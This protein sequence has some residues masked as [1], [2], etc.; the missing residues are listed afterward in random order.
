MIKSERWRYFTYGI[1]VCFI[2]MIAVHRLWNVVYV[3]RINTML[4]LSHSDYAE[5]YFMIQKLNEQKYDDLKVDLEKKLEENLLRFSSQDP[6]KLD[7][8]TVL[9]L[10]KINYYLL[11]KPIPYSS[12][13]NEVKIKSFFE[14]I[15]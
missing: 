10:R 12:K 5:P 3:D 15:Q 2:A 6:Q 8:G 11:I 9:L 4:D 1:L 7:E 14:M 13:E